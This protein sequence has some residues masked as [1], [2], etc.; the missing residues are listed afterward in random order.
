MHCIVYS[1]ENVYNQKMK[2][3]SFITLFA[4]L[5]FIL[6]LGL[7]VSVGLLIAAFFTNGI[8]D[9]FFFPQLL[10]YGVIFLVVFPVIMALISNVYFKT[11]GKKTWGNW[12]KISLNYQGVFTVIAVYQ[13]AFLIIE[14]LVFLNIFNTT[15]IVQRVIMFT[16]PFVLIYYTKKILKKVFGYTEAGGVSE[17]IDGEEIDP[18]DFTVRQPISSLVIYIVLTVM[19]MGILAVNIEMYIE[20]NFRFNNLIATFIMLPFALMGTFFIILWSRYKISIKGKQITATGYFRRKKSFSF[21]YITKAEYGSGRTKFGIIDTITAYHEKEKLF[22]ASSNCPGYQVL[23]Q[24][25]NNE[26]GDR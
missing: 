4:F 10:L 3:N 14:F 15:D 16:V 18:N 13:S 8:Q 5:G 12:L 7:F 23:A 25:L 19:F 17:L 21:D 2:Y 1:S 24:R 26:R 6:A 11:N 20:Y 9:L 22:T